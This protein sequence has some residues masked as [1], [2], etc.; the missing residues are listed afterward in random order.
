MSSTHISRSTKKVMGTKNVRK[1]NSYLREEEILKS[2][3]GLQRNFR[4]CILKNSQFFANISKLWPKKTLRVNS[5]PL[6]VF[7]HS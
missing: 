6:R 3:K 7:Y 2:V 5:V 1:T 4:K